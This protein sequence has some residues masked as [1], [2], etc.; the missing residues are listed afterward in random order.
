[1]I[2]KGLKKNFIPVQLLKGGKKII[3]WNLENEGKYY[4]WEEKIFGPEY[5][6][7]DI[8]NFIINYYDSLTKRKIQ[9]NFVWKEMIIRLTLENQNNYKTIYD[10]ITADA[11]NFPLKMRFGKKEEPIYYYFN[12]KEEFLEFY[13]DYTMY[14]RNCIEEGW[15]KKDKINWNNYDLIKK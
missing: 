12:S 11:I 7:N 10:G 3:M 4:S 1:M 5:T 6:F 15:K 8:Q 9:E 14:I 13:R 2:N